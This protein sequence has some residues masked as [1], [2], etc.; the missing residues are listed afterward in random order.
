[1]ATF[2]LLG[3]IVNVPGGCVTSMRMRGRFNGGGCDCLSSCVSCSGL[4][5]S[6][7]CGSSCEL[8]NHLLI[9]DGCG[10][11]S[12]TFVATFLTND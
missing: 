10:I 8:L 1:M 12:V 5:T 4:S 7:V 3:L 9:Q 2:L 6:V 11:K